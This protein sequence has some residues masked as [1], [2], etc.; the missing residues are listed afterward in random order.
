MR[1]QQE[2]SY[3]MHCFICMQ[4]VRV[5]VLISIGN[6]AERRTIVVCQ[7]CA[8]KEEIERE[9]QLIAE[10]IEQIANED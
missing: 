9:S 4:S 8:Y 6:F 5:A 3:G 2:E 1:R 10:M 7:P